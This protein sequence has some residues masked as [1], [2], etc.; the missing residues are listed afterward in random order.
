VGLPLAGFSA[1]ELKGIAQLDGRKLALLQGA[2]TRA[3]GSPVYYFLGEGQ[4]EGPLE[5]QSI[6]VESGKVRIKE[7]FG[8]VS[9]VRFESHPPLGTLV[10][11]GAAAQTNGASAHWAWLRLEQAGPDLVFGLYQNYLVERTLIRPSALPAFNLSLYCEQPVTTAD[12]VRAVENGLAEQGVALTKEGDK[13][14]IALPREESARLVAQ[15]RQVTDTLCARFS[16]PPASLR[17]KPGE[18]PASTD[19][20]ILPAG[21]INFPATDLSQVLMIYQE[22]INRTVLRPVTLPS[23]VIKL[24]TAT[25]LSKCEAIFVFTAT[26]TINGISVRPVADKFV[27]VYPSFLTNKLDALLARKTPTPEADSETIPPSTGGMPLDLKQVLAI[28][29]ELSGQP[30]ENAAGRNWFFTL[31][32]QTPLTKREALYAFDLLLGWEGLEVVPNEPGK[33]LKLVPMK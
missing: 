19:E 15:V 14:V 13:L 17:S 21:V 8:G 6:D 26:L 18:N 28:Y 31:R 3:R 32:S 1:V 25:P 22:L 2:P 7:D 12:V 4:R 33:G 27:F 20:E 30:V 11:P 10:R 24:K 29:G 16:K 23:P 9:E 5:V